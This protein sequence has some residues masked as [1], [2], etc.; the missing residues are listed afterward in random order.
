MAETD[1][2]S[3]DTAKT[4]SKITLMSA[5][6]ER[7]SSSDGVWLKTQALSERCGPWSC[8]GL[9]AEEGDPKMLEEPIALRAKS[10]WEIAEASGISERNA[11]TS[12]ERLDAVRMKN[13]VSKDMLEKSA[14]SITAPVGWW[15]Y[16][17]NGDSDVSTF[18]DTNEH[19]TNDYNLTA[20]MQPYLHISPQPL[21]HQQDTS[22]NEPTEFEAS[23]GRLPRPLSTNVYSGTS[24]VSR[25]PPPP[26]PALSAGPTKSLDAYTVYRAQVSNSAGQWQLHQNHNLF[27]AVSVK[28]PNTWNTPTPSITG[29]SQPEEISPKAPFPTTSD[30]GSSAVASFSRSFT[31]LPPPAPASIKARTFLAKSTLSLLLYNLVPYLLIL[32]LTHSIPLPAFSKVFF[33]ASS[34]LRHYRKYHLS[35]PAAQFLSSFEGLPSSKHSSSTLTHLQSLELFFPP[36][37]PISPAKHRC[38][39]RQAESF[40]SGCGLV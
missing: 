15:S 8:S 24:D 7:N 34:T 27:S 1:Q 2:I 40:N 17:E 28:T 12:V 18:P 35:C 22:S 13:A 10:R 9:V 30:S 4:D 36:L 19:F 33:T 26:P 3:L 5:A 20:S 29:R 25:M 6:V 39:S 37:Q 21:G 31:R 14:E 32:F 16:R 11:A 23:R 38:H